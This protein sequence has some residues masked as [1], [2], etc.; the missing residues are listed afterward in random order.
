VVAVPR[1]KVTIISF[2]IELP[3]LSCYLPFQIQE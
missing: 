1:F 3:F 2:H